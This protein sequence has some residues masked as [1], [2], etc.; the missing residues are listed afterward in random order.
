[1]CTTATPRE[2]VLLDGLLVSRNGR[3]ELKITEPMEGSPRYPRIRLRLVAYDVPPGWS[4]VLDERKEIS[5][6]GG[7][8]AIRCSIARSLLPSQANRTMKGASD[9]TRSGIGSRR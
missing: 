2:N 9:V 8:P 4:M 5:P 7:E 1:V 6:A 3:Y